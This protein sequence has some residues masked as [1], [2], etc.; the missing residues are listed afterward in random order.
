MM[1]KIRKS[2]MMVEDVSEY[3]REL[4][5]NIFDNFMHRR[6]MMAHIVQEAIIFTMVLSFLSKF[7]NFLVFDNLCHYVLG[8]E[9]H[10][11]CS[12]MIRRVC[13]C[14]VITVSVVH[15]EL[16]VVLSIKP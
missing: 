3:V 1:E 11:R 15:R 4:S 14:L 10:S 5:M 2:A 6:F 8:G 9:I 16:S 12:W 7:Y 13:L